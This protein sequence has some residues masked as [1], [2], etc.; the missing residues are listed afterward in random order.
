MMIALKRKTEYIIRGAIPVFF[1][2][3]E[4]FLQVIP[5]PVILKTNVS[6]ESLL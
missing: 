5:P 2:L 3:G 1:Q 6:L 4:T